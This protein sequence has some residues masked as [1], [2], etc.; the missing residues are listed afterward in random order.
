MSDEYI[1]Y[2]EEYVICSDNIK[3]ISRFC[4][5]LIKIMNIDA[6]FNYEPFRFLYQI[7]FTA[8]ETTWLTNNKP[9]NFN[10]PANTLY[11]AIISIIMS[12]Q[13]Y[14]VDFVFS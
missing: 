5:T 11:G 9:S 7:N 1:E 14:C 2:A 10:F 3:I 6:I 4:D 12:L 13:Y 8:R